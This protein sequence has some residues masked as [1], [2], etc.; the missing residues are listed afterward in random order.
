VACRLH[1]G[2]PQA[3]A[4]ARM[5]EPPVVGSG[6][7][8]KLLG[9]R[10]RKEKEV[11]ESCASKV[12]VDVGSHT[13]IDTKIHTLKQQRQELKVAKAAAAHELK[14]M[15][16]K[17]TRLKKKASQLNNNDLMEVFLMRQAEEKAKK[18]KVAASSSKEKV[19]SPAEEGSHSEEP[20]E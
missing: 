14:N 2:V 19:D 18:A 3:P 16:R 13:L 4:V 1:S 15:Q 5:A 6:L 17:R 11:E 9:K 7:K 8:Q 12:T 10:Q 20:P